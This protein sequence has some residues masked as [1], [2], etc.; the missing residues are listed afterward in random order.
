MGQSNRITDDLP[1]VVKITI[2]NVNQ[3]EKDIKSLQNISRAVQAGCNQTSGKNAASSGF[4]KDTLRKFSEVDPQNGWSAREDF[5]EEAYQGSPVETFCAAVQENINKNIKITIQNQHSN[6][7]CLEGWGYRVKNVGGKFVVD[8]GIPEPKQT[9]SATTTVTDTETKPIHPEA[10]NY[11]KINFTPEL[12]DFNDLGLNILTPPAKSTTVSHKWFTDPPTTA[13][14]SSNDSSSPS[15]T[16]PNITNVSTTQESATTSTST[17]SSPHE[18][19]KQLTS[20]EPSTSS[21][22]HEHTT[23]MTEKHSDTKRFPYPKTDFTKS[24]HHF[25]ADGST[26]GGESIPGLHLTGSS[27]SEQRN[28]PTPS[29][30]QPMRNDLLDPNPN[31]LNTPIIQGALGA[32]SVLQ[33]AATAII[34]LW[35]NNSK[36]PLLTSTQSPLL[37][38]DWV[39]ET[40]RAFPVGTATES[41]IRLHEESV[42]HKLVIIA[43]QTVEVI[44][45]MFNETIQPNVQDIRE[46]DS[47]NQLSAG[48]WAGIIAATLTGV[49]LLGGIGL[50][51]Y[52]YHKHK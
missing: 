18:V 23:K 43:K 24:S 10:P 16:L 17:S 34:G 9:I 27:A 12:I 13:A 32:G 20:T 2:G 39:N 42:R 1:A 45:E 19:T 40:A 29:H 48:A 14:S 11:G 46:N 51:I 35:R 6:K 50:S 5:W 15:P 3:A 4:I 52:C 28:N 33:T 22:P 41:D 47:N 21:T 7:L 31:S 49:T 26:D 37:E 30:F 38:N 25:S 8:S 36:Q 44:R